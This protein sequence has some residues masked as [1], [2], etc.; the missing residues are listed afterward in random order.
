MEHRTQDDDV[1]ASSL[2]DRLL[3]EALAMEAEERMR[4]LDALAADA[5]GQAARLR[6]LLAELDTDDDFLSPGG[7]L[8]GALF[9]ELRQGLPEAP[10]P[11][12]ALETGAAFGSYCI[13]EPIGAGGMGE[14]YRA[15]DT[16]LGRDV[17][18]KVLPAHLEG[19]S[20]RVARLQR[21]ARL[22]AA[23]NH[24]NIATIYDLEE[25]GGRTALVLEYV[26]GPTLEE[27][28]V[29]GPLPVAEALGIANQLVDA[30]EAAHARGVVH[31]DL[32][33]GNVK[34]TPSGRV[35]VLDFGIA[36]VRRPPDARDSGLLSLKTLSL[37]ASVIGT[38]AYMSPEQVR[39]E[40]IDHRTDI[41]AFGCVLFEMLAGARP[42]QGKGAAEMMTRVRERA[43]AFDLL[44][45]TVPA[46]VRQLIERCLRKDVAKRL[47]AIAEARAFLEAAANG[48][49]PPSSDAAGMSRRRSRV[50]GMW[51][52]ALGLLLGAA[53]S[54]LV[55]W[56]A[57]RP[58]PRAVTRLT[59][60]VPSTDELVTGALPAVALAPDGRTI[61]Y[62][63]RR[64]G[65]LQLYLRSL[66][67]ASPSAIE[68]SANAAAPFFS[69]DGAWVGFDRDGVL[70][71]TRATGGPPVVVCETGSAS[72]AA[73][74]SDRGEIVL[75]PT[76]GQGLFR[77]PASGGRP[78]PVTRIDTG[79]GDV[80]H[81]LP[82]VLPGGRA[83]LFTVERDKSSMIAAVRLDSGDVTPLT[84]G[85]QARYVHSGHIVVT[86]GDA[87]WAAPF[88]PD[89]LRLGADPVP[90][91][92]EIE[93]SGVAHFA[94]AR[95]GSLVYVPPRDLT[96]LR[97]LVWFD[98]DGRESPSGIEARRFL[99]LSLS[100]DGTRVALVI[101][102][103][104]RQDLW[105][106]DLSRRSMTQL[107]FDPHV[108]TAPIWTPDG[109]TIV[110]RSERDGGGLF[111]IA[112]DGIGGPQRLTRPSGAFYTP[113]TFTPD[114]KTLLFTEFRSYRDQGIGALD[115]AD[116]GNLRILVDE[117]FAELR[118]SLSPD[119]RW[120]AYQAD[121]T[122]AF[123]IYVR[124]YPDVDA[125][126][127]R[128]S[129]AGGTSPQWSPDGRALFYFENDTL[130]RVPVVD[131][132]RPPRGRP[133]RVFSA[134]LFGERL[135]PLYAIAPDGQRFLVIKDDAERDQVAARRQLLLVQNW[136]QELTERLSATRGTRP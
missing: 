123:E 11:A 54:G 81:T 92:D 36:T 108:D 76:N 2:E 35:K 73:S 85:R 38:A 86:R 14:V 93:P 37:P 126:T 1:P 130:M 51:P 104:G 125:G 110:F 96:P 136:V 71:K 52:G 129:T 77:V 132:R 50:L 62:R 29:A 30:L 12:P 57:M 128:V 8:G 97:D 60:P 120:L 90:V 31:R 107:T 4:W 89:A 133:Q 63:A 18:V 114:G 58:T 109:S 72:A 13:V 67:A 131:A 115:M 134:R 43:P 64:D 33:P 32:K 47:P 94:T 45:A 113:Y 105:V 15:R 21:E 3:D 20:E 98:R 135:G 122:G 59:V 24:P 16:R 75:A 53:V 34:I 117:P 46:A 56:S 26:E 17:A 79:R 27:R 40:P 74:W 83:A 5:P 39:G 124:R 49:R 10:A 106:H 84:E 91:L 19:Q 111:R 119:G 121:A 65:L 82:D 80:A 6:G 42:F 100:P 99:R 23:L 88:D 127:W 22:L 44:P 102:E 48:S 69:P 78:V 116:A 55:M 7:A 101:S 41:W 118:P 95:D 112:G 103:R 28:L 61:V 70:M 87:L 68:G 25:V 66:D 9:S